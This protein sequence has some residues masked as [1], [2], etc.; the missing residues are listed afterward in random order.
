MKLQN[1]SIDGQIYHS[2]LNLKKD[3]EYTLNIT[4]LCTHNDAD[5]PDDS[6]QRIKV[7]FRPGYKSSAHL[8]EHNLY[9]PSY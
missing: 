1:K 4:V 6:L 3:N 8:I 7:K 2:A 5:L 9:L